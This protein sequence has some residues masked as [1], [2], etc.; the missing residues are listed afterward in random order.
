MTMFTE[1]LCSRGVYSGMQR[2]ISSRC[3][4]RHDERISSKH[5]LEMRFS[6]ASAL[7]VFEFSF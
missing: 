6:M 7:I 1:R 2:H 5:A 3:V 4:R